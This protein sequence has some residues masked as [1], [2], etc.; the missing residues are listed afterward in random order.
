MM[1]LIAFSI[2][3]CIAEFIKV[4]PMVAGPISITHVYSVLIIGTT[5]LVMNWL[6]KKQQKAQPTVA[7]PTP[8]GGKIN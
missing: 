3:G 1:Y 6:K 2:N 5:L 8:H 4:N 7:K